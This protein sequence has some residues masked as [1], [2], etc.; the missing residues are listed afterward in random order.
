[1]VSILW[2]RYQKFLILYNKISWTDQTRWRTHVYICLLVGC[3]RIYCHSRL[4]NSFSVSFVSNIYGQ[5]W[6]KPKQNR[7]L[8]DSIFEVIISL[9]YHDKYNGC[10]GYCLTS[11]LEVP[12][13]KKIPPDVAQMHLRKKILKCYFENPNFEKTKNNLDTTIIVVF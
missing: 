11:I 7:W 13:L 9:R 4:L 2:S 8:S 1:M 12:K 6:I 10:H 3:F 5:R